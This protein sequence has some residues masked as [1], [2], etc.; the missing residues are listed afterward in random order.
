[1]AL[2]YLGR[3]PTSR[4]EARHFSNLMRQQEHQQ[5][6]SGYAD[7]GSI[8]R[9]RLLHEDTRAS[10]VQEPRAAPP[11]LPS[12]PVADASSSRDVHKRITRPSNKR[13]RDTASSYSDVEDELQ[14][15]VSNSQRSTRRSKRARVSSTYDDDASDDGDERKRKISKLNAKIAAGKGPQKGS[16]GPTGE[17]RIREDGRMEFRDVN[18]P[19]W[20]KHIHSQ[21]HAE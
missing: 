15:T 14:D 4:S 16:L 7:T 10:A 2:G 12:Q 5:G 8:D 13:T 1:M 19:E 11:I 3:I 6:S 20:S 21:Q 9:G 17:V 18:N